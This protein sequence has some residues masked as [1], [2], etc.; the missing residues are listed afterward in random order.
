MES[1]STNFANVSTVTLEPTA[2]NT[3]W[4]PIRVRHLRFVL[5]EESAHSEN[6]MRWSVCVRTDLKVQHATLCRQLQFRRCVP[7]SARATAN[8][9]KLQ[10]HAFA[11]MDMAVW[12]ALPLPAL[13]TTRESRA[14]LMGSVVVL[15]IRRRM[16][17][18]VIHV[19]RDPSARSAV[20]TLVSR[21]VDQTAN[22]LVT[23]MVLSLRLCVR[24][25]PNGRV[26]HA[27]NR[28]L[29][30]ETSKNVAR[31]NAVVTVPVLTASVN[32]KRSGVVKIARQMQALST[33][34]A[35][36]S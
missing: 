28:Q 16:L 9:M 13:P 31:W 17:A 22:A 36:T 12:I 32:A 10:S 25:T 27:H 2:S 20:L 21:C 4:R 11:K 19:S 30:L 5:V 1:A 23:R 24:A 14:Q 15:E 8:V 29:P 33:T 6:K 26:Q 35:R 7:T 18:N 3:L 34:R